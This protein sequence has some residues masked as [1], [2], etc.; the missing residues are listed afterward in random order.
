MYTTIDIV[1][2]MV[3]PMYIYVDRFDEFETCNLSVTSPPLERLSVL[4]T[5]TSLFH[6]VTNKFLKTQFYFIL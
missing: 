6:T 1:V 2:Y 3:A 5:Q 4:V